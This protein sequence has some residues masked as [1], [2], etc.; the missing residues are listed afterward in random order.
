M[1]TEEGVE[2]V[3]NEVMFSERKNFKLQEVGELSSMARL[4]LSH[5]FVIADTFHTYLQTVNMREIERTYEKEKKTH[6][7][8]CCIFSV[9]W[10]HQIIKQNVLLY[11]FEGASSSCYS[12][13]RFSSPS[14][15]PSMAFVIALAPSEVVFMDQACGLSCRHLD[16]LPLT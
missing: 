5:S 10:E 11:Y 15:D 12:C 14:Y 3:W 8:A 16:F 9:L 1:D 4:F 2:V 6:S 13:N 7:E